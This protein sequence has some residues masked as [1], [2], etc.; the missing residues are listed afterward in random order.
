M[1]PNTV[2]ICKG[3]VLCALRT[4]Y[5]IQSKTNDCLVFGQVAVYSIVRLNRYLDTCG[6]P[7]PRQFIT[8]LI[9]RLSEIVELSFYARFVHNKEN[10]F[11]KNNALHERIRSLYYD[12]K[13]C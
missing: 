3:F 9:E 5:K 12:L 7:Q 6:M 8:H 11:Y 13:G 10:P 2:G 4:L 1:I